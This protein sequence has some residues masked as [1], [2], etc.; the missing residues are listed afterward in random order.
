MKVMQLHLKP[1]LVKGTGVKL[2]DLLI[3]PVV[4]RTLSK[5]IALSVRAI[6]R[7]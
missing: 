7:G 2:F 5:L 6:K 1:E 4:Q 3:L